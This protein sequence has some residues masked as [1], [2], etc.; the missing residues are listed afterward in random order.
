[1]D[2]ENK[3]CVFIINENL[4]SGIAANT[5]AILGIT[6]GAKASEIVGADIIDA[7][8]HMHT[9]IIQFPVPILKC[10]EEK[11]NILRSKLYENEFSDIITV[12][13]SNIAQKCKTYDEFIDK[14]SKSYENDFHY[15]GIGLCG[16]KK[17]INKLT[18]NLPLLR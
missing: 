9:G 5:A 2:I 18:G 15:F 7:N 3:K 17:K 1:M 11:L 10:N 6:I 12:D 8:N 16:D 4:P 13:F 14:A